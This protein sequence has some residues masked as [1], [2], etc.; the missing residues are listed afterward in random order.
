MVI[1]KEKEQ[2]LYFRPADSPYPYPHPD[3]WMYV[4]T[5]EQL[6]EMSLGRKDVE[7]KLNQYISVILTHLLKLFYF[8]NNKD[9]FNGW[10]SSIF[11]CAFSVHKIKNPVGR[12][13]LP[14]AQTIYNWMW[15]NSEDSFSD[16]H[17]SYLKDFNNKGDPEY[18]D[19]PYIHN[20]GD[21]GM[22][23][24]FI[25]AYHIWLAKQLSTKGKVSKDEVQD[26][27]KD[28]LKKYTSN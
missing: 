16:W 14:D 3:D 15:G 18:R 12:D 20:G 5:E 6:Q 11:K 28:L 9:D 23:G 17:K 19:L 22:A 10:T 21:E 13:K 4:N 1:I 27:I 24:E 7:R 2:S 26:E 25:K 8:R